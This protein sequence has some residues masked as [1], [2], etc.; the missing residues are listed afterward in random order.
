MVPT[1]VS[2]NHTCALGMTRV[3]RR[4]YRHI[5]EILDERLRVPIAPTDH[6]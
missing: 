4:P 1:L 3:T 5:F 6:S 2:L